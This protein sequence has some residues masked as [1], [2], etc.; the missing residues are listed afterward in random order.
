MTFSENIPLAQY[1]TF[2]IGG[3]ARFLCIV[4]SEADILSAILFA[5]EKGLSFF[6]L[7][8]GSNILVSDAGY[9]G[10]VIKNEIKG[11]GEGE[12]DGLEHGFP[13]DK[14]AKV[15]N[16]GAGENWDQF[17]KFAVESEYYGI[18]NLSAI[19]GVVGATPVQ[20]I[21]AYGVDVSTTI[22]NV[23]AYDV[24]QEK[25]VD[26]SNTDCHFEYRSSIFK[27]S[28]NKFIISRVDFRLIKNG[29]INIG[30]K[31]LQN[32]FKEKS[33]REGLAS[34][35]GRES[36]TSD[37]Y[38]TSDT[39]P[40][41]QQVRDAVIY[42]RS[43]KLPD[44]KQWGTAGS[45]FKN[46]VIS[47]ESFDLLQKKYPDLPGFPES[48]GRV[49]VALGWILD[50]VCGAKG[51]VMGNVETYEKQ[52]LVLVSKPGATASEVIHMSDELIKIV[53]AKTGIEI[54]AEVEWVN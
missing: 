6:V 15:F 48:D 45:F 13:I 37:T 38:D 53:K 12:G 11:I 24:V 54:E 36:P 30:Y 27:K 4:K 43:Q 1:T 51:L 41:L 52:A 49:K 26:I 42:I 5:K 47:K 17:V 7:G 50:K 22:V 3:P 8:G 14:G 23:R 9:K 16:V 34:G 10:L 19:P 40:T 2:K 18:E 33:E 21:G 39:V 28:K 35:P 31:D 29:K 44:W 25:F 32:Y 46:P 20:N